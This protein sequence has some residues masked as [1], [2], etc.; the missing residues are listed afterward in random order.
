MINTTSAREAI[1]LAT[2][3]GW[4]APKEQTGKRQGKPD[5]IPMVLHGLDCARVIKA[6]DRIGQPYQAW[7]RF[8][9]ASPGWGS[10]LDMLRVHE[11]LVNA[12]HRGRTIRQPG[13]IANLALVALYD[14]RQRQRSQGAHKLAPAEVCLRVQVDVR[15]WAKCW[16]Q[17]YDAMLDELDTWDRDGL[18]PVKETLNEWAETKS[19][20]RDKAK[21]TTS[22]DRDVA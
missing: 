19:E 22:S 13:K 3:A 21:G 16:A 15:N 6:L 10:E 11:A 20:A 14:F 1:R 2:E 7:L 5:T 12:Y 18:A 9:Y 4:G 17:S 8:A